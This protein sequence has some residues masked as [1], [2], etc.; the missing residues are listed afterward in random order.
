MTVRVRWST[1]CAGTCGRT[2]YGGARA[3]R[4]HR[5][6]WCDGCTLVHLVSCDSHQDAVRVPVGAGGHPTLW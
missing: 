1:P 2:L 6:L 4:M 3:H 5:R